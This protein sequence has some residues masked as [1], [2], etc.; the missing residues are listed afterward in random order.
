MGIGPIVDVAAFTISGDGEVAISPSGTAAVYGSY[1]RL[2][3]WDLETGAARNE[4]IDDLD[5]VVVSIDVHGRL[6]VIGSRFGRLRVWDMKE[7]KTVGILEGHTGDILDVV[8]TPDGK[9]VITAARDDTIR[10]WDLRSG[11]QRGVLPGRGALADAVAIAPSGAYAYAIYGDTVVA[12]SIASG[13]RIGSLSL[14]HQISAVAVTPDGTRIALGDQ[15]GR[16]HFAQV[17]L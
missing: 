2:C 10:I 1:G 13:E 14:D 11:K 15:S 6:A 8:N 3:A 16:V 7:G 17:E 9:S 4:E 5:V 12:S